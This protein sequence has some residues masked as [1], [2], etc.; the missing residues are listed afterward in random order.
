MIAEFSICSVSVSP[1]NFFA[2]LAAKV[3]LRSKEARCCDLRASV[4]LKFDLGTHIAG[5]VKHKANL[6]A[7]LSLAAKE[8]QLLACVEID[9]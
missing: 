8:W 7:P 4:K 9:R 1:I 3:L 5:V 2:H 6:A